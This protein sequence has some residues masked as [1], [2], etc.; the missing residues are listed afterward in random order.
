MVDKGVMVYGAIFAE[1]GTDGY[2]SLR[3][4]RTTDDL[5]SFGIAS[6]VRILLKRAS[7]REPC[8]KE[9]RKKTRSESLVNIL[10]EEDD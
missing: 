4:S 8:Q 1:E 5:A 2:G 3:G 7:M 10:N 9:E 6:P